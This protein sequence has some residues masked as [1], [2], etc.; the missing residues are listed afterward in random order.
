MTV[1]SDHQVILKLLAITDLE[2]VSGLASKSLVKLGS[3]AIPTLLEALD[4][5]VSSSWLIAVKTLANIG[6]A[7]LPGLTRALESESEALARIE[8]ARGQAKGLL[9]KAEPFT[10]PVVAKGERKLFRARF[11]GLDRD[12]AEAVCKTLK[13]SDISCITVRN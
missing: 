4:S 5:P 12:Q 7:S 9:A 3:A 13:R 11:A 10:E 1:S 6:D 2:Y 8:A